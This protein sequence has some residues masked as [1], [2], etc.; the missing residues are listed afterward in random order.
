LSGPYD[1]LA[2]AGVQDRPHVS[3]VV[4][5]SVSKIR[6]AT[7]GSVSFAQPGVGFVVGDRAI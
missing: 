4:S 5:K 1:V 6:P 7:G 3:R 2:L